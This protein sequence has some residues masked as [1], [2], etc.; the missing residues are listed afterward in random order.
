MRRRATAGWPPRLDRPRSGSPSENSMG[1]F[2]RFPEYCSLAAT[3]SHHTDTLGCSRHPGAARCRSRS[4]GTGPSGRSD[5]CSERRSNSRKSSRIYRELL[6]NI[7]FLIRISRPVLT[8]WQYSYRLAV[9]FGPQQI[10]AFRRR[11]RNHL[12]L[13]GQFPLAVRLIV[14]QP[15]VAAVVTHVRPPIPTAAMLVDEGDDPDIPE[16]GMVVV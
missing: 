13:E 9:A 12:R 1:R 5:R 15:P 11:V 3:A 16:A 2:R 14:P 10:A 6:S 4:M 7:M 8:F